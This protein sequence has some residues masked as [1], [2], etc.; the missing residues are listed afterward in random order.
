[1]ITVMTAALVLAFTS[2]LAVPVLLL[3]VVVLQGYL[4][5]R[6]FYASM[7]TLEHFVSALAYADFTQNFTST[8]VD[9]ELNSTFNEI[10][11][12]FRDARADKEAQ[13]SYLDTLVKHIPVPLMA[14][15]VDGSFISSR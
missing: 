5:L 4:L 3:G 2:Y 14:V 10:L 12:R 11:E 13:A 15:A 1:M 7:T 6:F 8:N 9:A